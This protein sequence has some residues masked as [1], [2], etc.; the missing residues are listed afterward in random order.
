MPAWTVELALR[1]SESRARYWLPL[2]DMGKGDLDYECECEH[3]ASSVAAAG[4]CLEKQSGDE[5]KGHV[6]ALG[7]ERWSKVE[8]SG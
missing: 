6:V 1:A 2:R 3:L 8:C 7:S 5:A 4:A